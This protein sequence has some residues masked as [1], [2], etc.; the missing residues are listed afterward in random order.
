MVRTRDH[1][2]R[3]LGFDPAVFDPL[4]GAVKRQRQGDVDDAFWLVFLSVHFGRHRR[5][6]WALTCNFYNRLGQGG[7]WDWGTV[8][9]AVPAVRAWLDSYQYDLKRDGAGF[10][11]HRK[12][13][14]L[15][16]VGPNGTGETI[17]SYVKWIGESHL[18]RFG[19]L[20]SGEEKPDFATAFKS[21][22]AVNRF[23][24]TARFD[25]LST[26]GKLGLTDLVP[27]CAY[28]QNATGPLTGARLLTTGSR[29]SAATPADLEA[30]LKRVQERLAVPYDVLEDALCNW[31]KSPTK[32]VGFRG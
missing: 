20:G 8:R 23:G 31:Q 22:N 21:M 10:G 9:A 11:N 5:A 32:F 29:S 6:R 30:A 13:E 1:S 12:Y 2:D 4:M 19:H 16:G 15:R 14:S 7:S 26:L 27:D 25:Y 3:V 17:E 18:H 24:R 28:L